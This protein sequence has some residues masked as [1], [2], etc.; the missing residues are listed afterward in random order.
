M[1]VQK[2]LK[3]TFWII[4]RTMFSEAVPSN[5][6]VLKK[7]ILIDASNIFDQHE[8]LSFAKVAC[9]NDSKCIGIYEP[10][11]DKNGPF[12][13]LKDSFVA[14]VFSRN[15]IYRKKQYDPKSKCFDVSMYKPTS[16]F[17]WSFGHCSSSGIWLE[18]GTYTKQC[19][20]AK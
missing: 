8:Y 9:S 2:I 4:I 14:S 17:G 3:I 20:I 5:D 11:C 7:H 13:L 10:S 12:M 15:C 18:S 6:F 1:E 16:D 19:C